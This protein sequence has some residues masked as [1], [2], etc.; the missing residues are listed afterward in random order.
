MKLATE[1]DGTRDG[2]L[3]VISKDAGRAVPATGIA[4]TLQEALDHWEEA[5]PRLEELYSALNEGRAHDAVALDVERLMAPLPRAW[6]WLDGSAFPN[7]GELMQRAYNLPPLPSDPPLMYQGM[8]HQFLAATQDVL[9]PTEAD[10][11]DFEGELGVIL[12]EV[13][14][15]TSAE[16]ALAHV[17]LLIQ[18]NDWSLRAVGAAEMKTGFGWIQAKPAC[19]LAPFAVT[20]DELGDG[21]QNGRVNGTLHVRLNEQRFGDV[22]SREMQFGFGELV[23][24]AA[25][26]RTLCAGT[27]LGS[28]TVSSPDYQATGSCCIAERRAIET[29]D[30][31][32]PRTP[33][34]RFGDRVRMEAQF[35][36]AAGDIDFTPSALAVTGKLELSHPIFAQA[37]D[38]LQSTVSAGS[39]P[40]LTIPSPSMVHYRGGRKAVDATVYPRLEDFYDDL[41]SVYSQQVAALVNRGCTYLQLDDTSLAY[42]NDPEQRAMIA[43]EG[44]DPERQ[45]EIYIGIINQALEGRSK[46]LT[47]TTHLCRGNFRSSWVASGS[48]DYVADALF[49]QLNVDGYFLEFD[50]ERSGGFEPLRLLPKGHKRVAL[51]LITTKRGGLEGRDEILRRIDAAAKFAP[52]DQLCLAPQ[53]GFSSTFEGNDITEDEQRAK[54]ELIVSLAEEVWGEV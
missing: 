53:C 25:R 11:I 9:L 49:N 33:F 40:K 23:A 10:G 15:G 1:I 4:K 43:S 7:H 46:D 19:S 14:L 30:L 29:I 37:F 6:Q 48:Y 8:S 42:L 36:N 35:H 26:T 3:L 18:I 52:L 16:E 41:A 34:M 47:V 21:W 32:A 31:G 17:K 50:D 12:S 24:H 54:L 44:G 20:P 13:P 2:R 5:Q 51:G 28:G 39:V 38:F 27:V 45:H 22:P